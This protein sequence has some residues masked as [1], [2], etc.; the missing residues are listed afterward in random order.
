MLVIHLGC[1]A[2]GD[3]HGMTHT[4]SPRSH[5]SARGA[6]M[7]TK[8]GMREPWRGGGGCKACM[9]AEDTEGMNHQVHIQHA[10]SICIACTVGYHC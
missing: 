7:A 1:A 5:I 9:W 10:H 2:N 3:V 8:W 4:T 6:K